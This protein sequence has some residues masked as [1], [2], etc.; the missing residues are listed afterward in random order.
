MRE[1]FAKVVLLREEWVL[2][3][4]N[5]DKKPP[6]VM[7]PNSKVCGVLQAEALL[8]D[9]F[10]SQWV[11]QYG[12]LLQELLVPFLDGR[13]L[14]KRCESVEHRPRD[15]DR[16]L[17]EDRHERRCLVWSFR[18]RGPLGPR[19]LREASQQVHGGRLHEPRNRHEH[20]HAR[21]RV[22][23]QIAEHAARSLRGI[24]SDWKV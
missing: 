20:V 13:L 23:D 21:P 14:N 19:L 11:E 10:G 2:R 24:G 18:E 3:S 15:L 1:A 4:L 5:L 16:A 9:D 12:V 6:I 17:R 8:W 22:C 7:A